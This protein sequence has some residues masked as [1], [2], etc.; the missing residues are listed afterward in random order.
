MASRFPFVLARETVCKLPPL[1]RLIRPGSAA[2]AGRYAESEAEESEETKGAV[3]PHVERSATTARAWTS[4]SG[5]F[6]A[7]T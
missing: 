4:P 1:S 2:G 3:A 6:G 5:G 7:P